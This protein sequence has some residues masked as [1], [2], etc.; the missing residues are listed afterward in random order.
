MAVGSAAGSTAAV[1]AA[2]MA[3]AVG[4]AYAAVSIYWGLGGTRWWIRWA[5]AWSGKPAA[6]QPAR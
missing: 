2:W 1:A 6:D 4:A 3:F 5:A